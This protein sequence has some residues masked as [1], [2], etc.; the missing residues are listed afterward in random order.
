MKKTLLAAAFCG[1]ALLGCRAPKYALYTSVHRDFQ[2]RVPWAWS[3]LF[4][5]EEKHFTNT[6]FI[7][8]FEPDFYLGAPSFGVRWYSRYATHRL[9]DGRLEMY[10]GA[11]DFIKQTLHSVYGPE[12]VMVQ[13][14]HEI[15]VA[16]RKAKHFVALCAGPAHP[17]ARWGTAVDKATG[18]FINPRKHAYAVLPMPSGFYVIVY[19]ATQQGFDR[20]ESQFNQLVNTFVPLKDGPGGAQLPPSSERQVAR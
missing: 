2:C 12:R 10:A 5:E 7:G 20:Y 13:D 6:A 19:P 9:R 3:V 17:K 14:V 4:D 8:P 1:L 16:G 15:L 11:D 18:A